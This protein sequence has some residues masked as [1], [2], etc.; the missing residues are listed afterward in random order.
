MTPPLA[1]FHN[2]NTNN[3][4]QG[5]V[6]DW[7]KKFQAALEE[8]DQLRKYTSL[9]ML[10]NDFIAVAELYGKIIISEAFLE[11]EQK[12]IKPV[13]VGYLPLRFSFPLCSHTHTHSPHSFTLT[14][15]SLKF[16]GIAGGTKYVCQN[17]LFKFARDTEVIPS[18][19]MYGGSKRSDEKAMKAARHELKSLISLYNC[20]VYG[21]N[22]PLMSLIHYRGFCLIAMS[23]LPID[24]QD[25]IV[26]GSPDGGH[27]VYAEHQ[28]MNMLMEK[29]GK[30]LNLQAHIVK[31]KILYGPGDIEGHLGCDGKFYLL[32][33]SRLFPPEAPLKG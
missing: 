28:T 1:S 27:T 12:S 4:Q 30:A 32:D 13:S 3:S 2:N 29:A 19:W 22:F 5:G 17:I 24:G 16:G 14:F 7:N 25:T 33:F 11:I 8:T 21:L 20:N 31:N 23:V 9:A 26:Y 15:S 10:G 6:I 18:T